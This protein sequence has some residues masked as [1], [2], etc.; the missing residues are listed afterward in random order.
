MVVDLL[1]SRTKN[2]PISKSESTGPESQNSIEMQTTE[3]RIEGMTCGHCVRSV[4]K[5]LSEVPG[6][7]LAQV[8]LDVGT[9]TIEHDGSVTESSLIA[10]V[11]EDGYVAK[12]LP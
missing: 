4:T 10:A 1:L 2:H 3:L 9:A 8:D 5:A 7:S 6:V 12:K 11:Q